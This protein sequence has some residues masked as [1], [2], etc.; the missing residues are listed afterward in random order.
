MPNRIIKESIR[1]SKTVNTMTDFQFRVWVYLITYVDDYGRGSA[2]PELIKGLVF[3][4]RK[5]L[6][7]SDIEKALED[8]AGMGC[9]S[10]YSVDGESY[11]YFP[12]WGNHQR[13][14]SKKSKFPSPK[15]PDSPLSTVIH[16][17]QPPESNPIR[18][19]SESESGGG[20]RT[21]EAA[22][23]AGFT[24]PPMSRAVEAFC[25]KINP[26]PSERS[27]AELESFEAQMGT[28]CCL[29]AIDEALDARATSW[30]Y[31][32]SILRSKLD[33]GVRCIADWGKLE[34]KRNARNP[35]KQ[36]AAGSSGADERW[37]IKSH[38]L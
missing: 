37:H 26:T 15:E 38:T 35:D 30:N 22:T 13:I 18:I 16:R 10:L 33:Q 34:E 11:F 8:L 25:N 31:I 23:T 3:P 24:L 14:Q 29:R 6:A 21:R 19:Q 36:D 12:N 5:R 1:T 9:I 32:R 4:R 2:D 7:E 17:D 28:E 27:L 20:T